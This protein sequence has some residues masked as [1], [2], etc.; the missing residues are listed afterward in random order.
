MHFEKLE[1]HKK[2]HENL[3]V[4]Q[5]SPIYLNHMEKPTVL[6][7]NVNKQYILCVYCY[8]TTHLEIPMI[9]VCIQLRSLWN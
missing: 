3:Y 9:L 5:T 7:T 1:K 2:T 4:S 8:L 6:G